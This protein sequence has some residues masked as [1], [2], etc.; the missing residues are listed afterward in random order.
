MIINRPSEFVQRTLSSIIRQSGSVITLEQKTGPFGLRPEVQRIFDL[1]RLWFNIDSFE[2]VVDLLNTVLEPEADKF[3]IIG[4]ITSN[5][6][7]YGTGPFASAL[8]YKMKK[9]LVFF[10]E[11]DFGRFFIAPLTL[12]KTTFLQSKRVL[13]LKDVLVGG[14]SL[15]QI[16]TI[17][18]ES[19]AR[20]SRLVTLID[21]EYQNTLELTSASEDAI[22]MKLL[23]ASEFDDM[24]ARTSNEH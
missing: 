11:M 2:S 4:G 9:N 19:Q 16:D 21:F 13:L 17:L 1:D 12:E 14:R 5:V 18:A 23:T 22:Y 10:C 3:E 7:S 6:G 24:E 15:T 8:A 20:V